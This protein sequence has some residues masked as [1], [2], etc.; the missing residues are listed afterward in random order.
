[1]LLRTF[2]SD[3]LQ[4]GGDIN[5]SLTKNIFFIDDEN[6]IISST[7]KIKENTSLDLNIVDFSSSDTDLELS[8]YLSEYSSL[9]FSLASISKNND[10]KIYRINVYHKEKDSSSLISMVGINDDKAVLRFKQYSSIDKGSVR[11]K[12]R[13]EGRITNLS[14][15]CIS[16]SSPVLNINENDVKASHGAALGSYSPRDLYYL[17]SRG[18]SLKESKIILSKGQFYPVLRKFE[19]ENI[20]SLLQHRIEEI[21]L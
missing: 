9:N 17:N 10:K 5:S 18:L 12:T 13:Q 19:D 11:A 4:L 20:Y 14:L 16:E 15:N 2:M 3:F 21:L 6:I 1:M 7:F 8:F